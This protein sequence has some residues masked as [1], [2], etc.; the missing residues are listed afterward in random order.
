M[1]LKFMSL[2]FLTLSLPALAQDIQALNVSET[3]RGFISEHGLDVKKLQASCVSFDACS[4]MNH[5]I[6]TY[7]FE[8]DAQLAFE[9]LVSLKPN[10]LWNGSS[11]FQLEYDPDSNSF[12]DKD[13]ELPDV[14]QGQIYFLELDITK[15]K[16][17]PVAFEVVELNAETRTLAFS[18]LKQN[19]SKGIQRIRFEQEGKNFNIIH[20][21]HFK[22][23]SFLRDK[24]LYGPF[25][26]MILNDFW[27]AFEKRL[28]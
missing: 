9:K 8:G 17:I 15:K 12:L 6:K 11:R 1:K 21:S 28:E 5:H 20:E 14:K 16:K 26:T 25:H 7:T 24:L 3:V 13:R 4:H 23:D 2:A 22:S 19:K 18:Y 10:E 27:G